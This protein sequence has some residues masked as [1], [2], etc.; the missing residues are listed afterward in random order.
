[1]PNIL[2]FFSDVSTPWNFLGSKSLMKYKSIQQTLRFQR[3]TKIIMLF[4]LAK[5][6]RRPFCQLLTTHISP[7]I[8]FGKKK[9][10]DISI[11]EQY[12]IET[13]L[14]NSIDLLVMELTKWKKKLCP[15]WREIESKGKQRNNCHWRSYKWMKKLFCLLIAVVVGFLFIES[16]PIK[17]S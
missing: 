15:N 6:K 16:N 8:L 17:C 10:N 13:E 2:D 3:V 4:I 12:V 9:W 11:V 1:M 7:H 14:Q 5:W